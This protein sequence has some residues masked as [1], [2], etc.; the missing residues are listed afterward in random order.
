MFEC[1]N[2]RI[3]RQYLHS[4]SWPAAL[5]NQACDRCYCDRCYP[6]SCPDTLNVAGYIYVIPRGW[7]RFGVFV[8]EGFAQ[9][10]NVWNT[11]LNCYHGTSIEKAKSIV[12][13]R[14]LLLPDDITMHGEKL[15]ICDGHIPTE[16]FVFTTP[17]IAYAQ[18]PYYAR[19]Y[20]FLSPMNL[21]S[22]NIT[23]VLQCKQ[24]MYS[25]IVQPETVG[26]ESRGERICPHIPNDRLEW[27]TEQRSAVM[28]YGLLLRIQPTMPIPYPIYTI[29]V[30]LPNRDHMNSNQDEEDLQNI[31]K[32]RMIFL[33]VIMP[34]TILALIAF[35]F[36]QT[37]KKKCPIQPSIPIWLTV[38]G[39]VGLGSLCIV[40][41][42]FIYYL[43]LLT[44]FS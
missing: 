19:V 16:H 15:N 20:S 42:Q 10:H 17:S 37:Y 6:P 3:G 24:K 12:E 30:P 18:L 2:I 36:G 25:F 22:Y 7:T 14:Q 5:R 41:N 13:H 34:F 33:F 11:W 32:K 1:E 28:P 39:A 38:F 26:A 43:S 4:I 9:H 35:I 8:D 27:K 21:K 23:V 44:N 31:T 29:P 40:T